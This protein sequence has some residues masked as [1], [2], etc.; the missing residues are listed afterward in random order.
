MQ[1]KRGRT[2]GQVTDD[3]LE[4]VIIKIV[5]DFS[6]VSLHFNNYDGE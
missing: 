6:S 3:L 2:D 5:E 1:E 4:T